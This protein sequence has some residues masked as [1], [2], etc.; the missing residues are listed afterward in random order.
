[1]PKQPSVYHQKAMKSRIQQQIT[2]EHLSRSAK[3]SSLYKKP[4]LQLAQYKRRSYCHCKLSDFIQDASRQTQCLTNQMVPQDPPQRPPTTLL[5]QN[6]SPRTENLVL[7]SPARAKNRPPKRRSSRL[8]P[9]HGLPHCQDPPCETISHKPYLL[10]VHDCGTGP[11]RLQRFRKRH[12]LNSSE[13]PALVRPRFPAQSS[14][15]HA[16]HFIGCHG[17]AGGAGLCIESESAVRV[18]DCAR[19]AGWIMVSI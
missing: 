15:R 18:F 17:A 3:P 19:G 2:Q 12:L 7:R 13:I 14:Q 6:L 16:L 9:P 1:M 5:P 4:C 10:G 8:H 11:R